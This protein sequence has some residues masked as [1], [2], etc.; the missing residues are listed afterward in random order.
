MKR[1]PYLYIFTGIPFSGKTTRAKQLHKY[2]GAIHLELDRLVAEKGLAETNISPE[3]FTNLHLELL[4]QAEKYLLK[5][6]DV[7]YDSSAHTKERRDF[8]RSIGKR[9]G[10]KTKLIYIATER[11]EARRRWERNNQTRERIVVHRVNFEAITNSYVPPSNEDHVTIEQH[12]SFLDF[13]RKLCF[14]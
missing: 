4:N 8:I 1:S 2:T 14:I 10:A 5:G 11:E 7:I 3:M 6:K 13:V 12:D 9:A